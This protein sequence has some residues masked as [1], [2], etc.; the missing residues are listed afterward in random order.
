MQ[1]IGLA[2]AA[3]GAVGHGTRFR[4]VRRFRGG[5][6]DRRAL[7]AFR[8]RP[9]HLSAP[10][11]QRGRREL[12]RCNSVEIVIDYGACA[13]RRSPR[14]D[15]RRCRRLLHHVVAG[16]SVGTLAWMAGAMALPRGLSGD[17]PGRPRD[18]RWCASAFMAGRSPRCRSCATPRTTMRFVARHPDA[19]VTQRLPP[20]RQRSQLT[21]AYFVAGYPA[22]LLGSPRVA[23]LGC[24]SMATV[25]SRRLRPFHR[26][27]RHRPVVC[28]GA[29]TLPVVQPARSTAQLDVTANDA[30]HFL[31]NTPATTTHPARHPAGPPARSH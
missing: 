28:R 2:V 13:V 27:R 20:V 19:P 17:S 4:L 9:R 23:L 5:R 8:P 25:A 12:R 22:R 31:A 3:R 24:G 30:K 29:G 26:Y 14:P 18:R 6:G 11:R 7:T 16:M 10:H 15:M 21:Y 1:P